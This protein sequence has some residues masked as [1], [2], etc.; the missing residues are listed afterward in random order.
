MNERGLFFALR[1]QLRVMVA[2]PRRTA[3]RGAPRGA[4]VNISSA[5]GLIGLPGVSAYVAS[6]HAVI[7]QT[8]AAA[9]DHG[10]DGIRVNAVCP[11][12]I[13]TP[14]SKDFLQAQEEAAKTRGWPIPLEVPP[15][16]TTR[17]VR[18]C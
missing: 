4:I 6:K 11:G 2:Q 15:P 7:G 12:F 18:E 5:T 1:A 14:M 16:P 9:A 8:K 17:E 10:K 13:A 3:E